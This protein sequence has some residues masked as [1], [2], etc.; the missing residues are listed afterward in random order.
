MLLHKTPLENE[1]KINGEGQKEVS[2]LHL[3]NPITMEGETGISLKQVDAPNAMHYL[4]ETSYKTLL[5]HRLECGWV[6]RQFQ[7]IF[8][9]VLVTLT[10]SR[11]PLFSFSPVLMATSSSA[12]TAKD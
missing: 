3:F 2:T 1:K 5:M 8:S 9:A 4:I 11:S 7:L 6:K 12:L 10:L